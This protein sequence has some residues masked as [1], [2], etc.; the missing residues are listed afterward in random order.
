MRGA[1]EWPLA[2]FPTLSSELDLALV[3]SFFSHGYVFLSPGSFEIVSDLWGVK[4]EPNFLGTCRN[5]QTLK[6]QNEIAFEMI[7][8]IVA[9]TFF[10]LPKVQ[11]KYFHI[12]ESFKWKQ[13]LSINQA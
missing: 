2:C 4:S 9:E 3:P 12:T 5:T 6:S 11:S 8:I 13:G 7:Y 10:H 1:L